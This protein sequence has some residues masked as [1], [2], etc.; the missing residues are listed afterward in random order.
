MFLEKNRVLSILSVIYTQILTISQQKKGIWKGNKS[1][2]KIEKKS[3]L[4]ILSNIF[5]ERRVNFDFLFGW[6]NLNINPGP[7]KQNKIE[8]IRD[9]QRILFYTLIIYEY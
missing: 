2:I 8:R 9:R 4:K 6:K 7:F 5:K 3:G 1:R